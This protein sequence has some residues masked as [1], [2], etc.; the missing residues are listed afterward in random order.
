M[1]LALA[2]L[3]AAPAMAQAP[4]AAGA[5][6]PPAENTEDPSAGLVPPTLVTDALPSYPPDARDRGIEGEVIVRI[7]VLPDGSVADPEVVASADT[8]LDYAALEAARQLVFEPATLNGTPVSV[9]LD[10]RFRFSLA[11]ADETG[12][13]APGSLY[14]Q[15][16][17][18]MGLAVPNATVV[19]EPRGGGDTVVVTTTVEGH[20]HSSFLPSDTYDVAASHSGFATA[21]TTVTLK[22]G[23]T[24]QVAVT[25]I[26]NEGSE[27]IVIFYDR[28]TWREVERG[29]IEASQ[30]TVTGQYTLT[31][32]DMESTPG[33]LEDVTRAVH[34]LPGVVSDGDMLAAF[35]VRGGE[36][37]DVMFLLDRI[38]L[39]NPFHLAGFNSIYN[40]DMVKQVRFF[41]GAPP[42][43]VPAGLSAVMDVESWDGTPRQ[44]AH[45]LDGALDISMSTARLLVMGPVGP[46]DDATIAV[47]ARRSYIEGYFQAMKWLNVIDSA[48]AAPEYSELSARFAWRPSDDHRIIITALRTDDSLALVNSG[49]DS[50]ISID[51]AFELDN[52]LYLGALDHLWTPREDLQIHTTT[53][54]STDRGHTRRDLGGVVERNI[55]THQWYGRTD[56]T[57]AYGP[58]TIQAGVDVRWLQIDAEGQVEDTRAIPTWTRAPLADQG[59]DLVELQDLR[60]TPEASLYVQDT[61]APGPVNVRVGSRV[62][63]TGFTG[64]VLVSPSGGL[65]VPLK[66]GTIPK[67]SGGVYYRTP[68][69][70]LVLD[71]TLGN[72]NISSERGFHLVAGL[73]QGIPL[74]GE[75]AGGLVR[76]EGYHI[77]LDNLVVNPDTWAAVENGATYSNDGTGRNYGV[78]VMVAA[79]SG[80][81]GGM[82]TYGLLFAERTNPLNQ[83]YAQT[84]AP[85]Q[86]QRHTV[87]VALEFQATT[88]WKF[89]TR[90]SFHTGRPMS[91]VA[92]AGEDTV[93]I[94]GL[95]DTRLGNFHSL[96]LRA[97]WRKAYRRMRLS[98]YTEVLNV[99]N[100]QSDFLPIVTV[101][102]DGELEETMLAHLPV[103]PFLGVR[104]D[105]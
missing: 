83:V 87:G 78:D 32:R 54:Y 3:V 42:A 80:R 36:A 40:P 22:A 30:G 55:T 86:D 67:I 26:P 77:W 63:W 5:E 59:L 35:H 23:E 88:R 46:G 81:W 16:V 84:I 13:A 101:G 76:V 37:T 53:G 28:Q 41:A 75:K 27:E 34:A 65:S 25:L 19:L 56:G 82:A 1:L 11:L 50:L 95:N 21:H 91:T 61:W 79:R 20:F 68:Q 44:D 92:A 96:D 8:L 99:F 90:Y 48:F 2:A 89:T 74:P 14:G 39:S 29:S 12:N 66:T 69:D 62:K 49:D 85:Y 102:A 43:D 6:A 4:P 70:P 31:R 47:A 104:A 45:D 98:V 60:P 72:P 71:E 38:P 97:E 94:V 52:V 58:H 100:T 73:D 24:L 33:A 18:A 17:D 103:R 64:E 93:A 9:Q 15:V 51:G 10:Y 57:L 105:F 7:W